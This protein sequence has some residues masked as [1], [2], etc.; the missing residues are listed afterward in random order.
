MGWER[1]R[2]KLHE[3]N[4][5]LRGATDTT[6]VDAGGSAPDVP[7]GVRYVI[8][9]DADTR[10]PR[11]AARRLIGKMA[12]PLN[13]P[14][15]DAATGR[16][17]EGYAVLQPRVTPSL[18]MGRE[19]S[20]FQRIVSSAPGLDPYA[21]AVS[22]VYQ[23]LFGEGSYA[24][25]GIYDIDAFEA[26]L[27]GRVR[28]RHAAQPRPVRGH[29]CPRRTR[30]RYRGRRG[31]SG[32]L[33][34]R[35]RP[36]ASLGA[37]R[38]AAAAVA[39]GPARCRRGRPASG[40]VPLIGLWKM[41]DNL[42]RTLSAPAALLA[43]VAGWTLP[44][45]AALAWTAFILVTDRR[46]DAAAGRRGDRAAARRHHHAQPPARPRRGSAAGHRPDAVPARL[47]PPPG[48][49]DG[50]CDRADA[51]SAVRESTGTCSSGS[52]RRR[53]PS[54]R[55]P[56]C[57]AYYRQMRGSVLATLAG[58]LRRLR[59][60]ARCGRGSRP[61]SRLLWLAAP[62]LAFWISR[63]PP[64]G[65]PAPRCRVTDARDLRL[66]ARRTWRFFETFVT[67]EDHMLPPDNFQED[68]TAGPGPPHLAHQ[69]RPVPAVHRQRARLRLDRDGRRAGAAGSDARHDGAPAALPRPLLQLVRHA[70]PA[71]AGPALRLVGGQR[72]PRRHTWLPPRM[73]PGSGRT[74]PS[75]RRRFAA[76]A[77]DAL[78]LAREALHAIPAPV[79]TAVRLVAA[80]RDGDR[81]HRRHAGRDGASAGR[82]PAA[83]A[84]PGAARRHPARTSPGR[85]RA[86]ATMTPA[87]TCSSGRTQPSAPSRAGDATAHGPRRPTARA[88]GAGW[89]PWPTPCGRWPTRWSSAF[90]S[91]RSASCCPS[92]TAS[93]TARSTRA[94]TT[95]SP[96][97]RGWRA[98][99]RSPR[100]TSPARHWFRL[101]PRRSR[102]SAPARR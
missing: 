21:A 102:R 25:K 97:R 47:P 41:L 38:L 70:R 93:P 73:R 44:L 58:L 74:L 77:R 92:A 82:Q 79:R 91:T 34:R 35:C 57:P 94:A 18:P 101:G 48:L 68:P 3:L 96:P 11:D 15:F 86:R 76:G 13:R 33:R 72:Q 55:G 95:C 69:H 50:R 31:V 66:V 52:P 83:P 84:R 53:P 7:T 32:A 88:E 26:A 51:V 46:A 22:D 24:G 87:A 10:L 80:A 63:S 16:V 8:T 78:D 54:A 20:L 30:V 60:R 1:K 42:R 59:R 61:R 75:R 37:R 39:A 29:L 90:C 67:A 56:A 43:L 85:W 65:A 17:V 49:A 98:S 19:G 64:A 40:S 4:R 28:R 71:A 27:A 14:R 5:L 9:L 89:R 23:D 12:H 36:P 6:F 62:A 2:G 99:S 81:P 100:A 45:P